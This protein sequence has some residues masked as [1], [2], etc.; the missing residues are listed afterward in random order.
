MKGTTM[1]AESIYRLWDS[2]FVARWHS[3]SDSRL[4]NSHDLNQ[5]HAGRVAILAYGLF[6]STQARDVL[7]MVMTALLHDAPEKL[8]GDVPHVGKQQIKELSVGDK[9]GARL[10]ELDMQLP[11]FQKGPEVGLCD[12]LDAIMFMKKEA[13]ELAERED[14]KRDIAMCMKMAAD[15][16]VDDKVEML[17]RWA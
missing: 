2:G 5:G 4:R 16:E 14:W 15:L 12:L 10:W 1:K 6:H 9:I 17:I 11:Y 7:Q 13:P 3:N 8:T